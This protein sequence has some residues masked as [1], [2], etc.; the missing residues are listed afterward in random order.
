MLLRELYELDIIEARSKPDQNPKVSAYEKL[1]PYKDDPSIYITFTTLNKAGI[2]PKSSFNTPNGVYTFPLA[3]TW[4]QYE[5]D[6]YKNFTQYPDFIQNRPYIQVLKYTGYGRQLTISNNPDTSNYTNDDLQKDLV[7]LQKKYHIDDD[8]INQYHQSASRFHGHYDEKIPIEGPAS[9]LWTVTRAIAYGKMN[10]RNQSKKNYDYED[11]TPDSTARVTNDWASVLRSL[12][13]Q[14]IV[15][16]FHSV[17][18]QSEPC[19]A[20]FLSSKAFKRIDTALVTRTQE[21][22]PKS[23]SI[24]IRHVLDYTDRNGRD[25]KV[26]KYLL[27]IAS[28]EDCFTYW[29]NVLE[30][31]RWPDFEARIVKAN[32]QHFFKEYVRQVQERCPEL[33]P[34]ILK[35]MP[36]KS[37]RY[38]YFYVRDNVSSPWPDA[39]PSMLESEL[40]ELLLDY[41]T[42]ALKHRWPEAEEKLV[43]WMGKDAFI[44]HYY[45]V[46]NMI[47]YAEQFGISSWPALEK[48]LLETQNQDSPTLLASYAIRVLKHRWPD[49]EPVIKKLRDPWQ[50]YASTFPDVLGVQQDN[51]SEFEKWREIFLKN[52]AAAINKLTPEQTT[53][54]IMKAYISTVRSATYL[55]TTNVLNLAYNNPAVAK[56]L[57]DGFYAF[58]VANVSAEDLQARI[59]NAHNHITQK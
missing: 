16:E 23:K 24:N 17:I 27:K 2:N 34:E 13:F 28:I 45:Y 53:P 38:A 58:N 32:N 5:V 6:Y 29:D 37:N 33:E 57:L 7:K 22:I 20:V 9:I 10:K 56:E 19:Q 35:R 14:L 44:S 1:L 36:F 39:E 18:H 4:Q 43:E 30:F 41:T 59:N 54:V 26:E 8:S 42:N 15:D 46:N 40:P 48:K 3:L 49:A 31:A 12:G 52:G 55:M 50:L 25:E 47:E 51:V 21:N 11:D